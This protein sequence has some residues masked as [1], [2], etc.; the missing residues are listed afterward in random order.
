MKFNSP[1]FIEEDPISIPH[2]FEQLQDIE[3]SGFFSAIFAWGLRK[4]IIKKAMELMKLFD[5]APYD[6]MLNHSERDLKS[7]LK[8]KHRTF[9]ATDLL[10]F[11]H[12][13]KNYYLN[14]DS[15]ETLF[16]PS[17][18]N[19]KNMESGIENFYIHFTADELMPART[20]KHVCF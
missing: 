5:F 8:F 6:F 12:F 10:Y 16:I 2:N 13:F 15:L 11:V 17:E 18:Q 3:I 4:T 14:N 1:E 9:D 19:N 7:L 20:A